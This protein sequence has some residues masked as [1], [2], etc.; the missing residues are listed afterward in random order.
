MEI[1]QSLERLS[2]LVNIIPPLISKIPEEEFNLNPAPGK[3]SKKQILG[4]LLDSAA[5]NHQRFVRI[6]F[7]NVPSIYYDQD[8]WNLYNH[9]QD[10]SK[11]HLIDFW[12]IYNT[13]LIQLVARIPAENLERKGKGKDGSLNSLSWYIEDYV[14]HMEHHLKQIVNY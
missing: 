10:L 9:H 2:H 7:E 4:H 8:N 12:T 13:H 14:K 3:W 5:N 6:Q 11:K 1:N